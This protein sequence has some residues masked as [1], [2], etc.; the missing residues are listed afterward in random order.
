MPDVVSKALNQLSNDTTMPE[1]YAYNLANETAVIWYSIL[2]KKTVFNCIKPYFENH[3]KNT[4]IYNFVFF[5]L[6]KELN[7]PQELKWN[8]EQ[9]N[10]Q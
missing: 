10:V 1:H 3:L 4:W 9:N 5:F 7:K 2:S 6:K 8:N